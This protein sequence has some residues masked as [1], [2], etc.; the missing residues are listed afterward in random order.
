MG[1]KGIG[2]LAPFGIARKV[3]VVTVNNNRLNHFTLHLGGILQS[4]REFGQYEPPFESYD[5]AISEFEIDELSAV[6]KPHVA[7]LISNGQ[8]TIV[9]ASEITTSL[10]FDEIELG[11]VLGRRFSVILLRHDFSVKINGRELNNEEALPEFEFRIPSDAGAYVTESFKGQEVRFWAGFVGSADWPSDEA[12]VGIYAHGKIVQDRPFFFSVKGKELFQRYLY[13]VVEADWIDEQE[14]DLVST[15]RTSID[16]SDPIVDGFREWGQKKVSTW[17]D[18]YTEFRKEKQI[19]EL[20]DV[21]AKRRKEKVIPTFSDPE[22]KAIE[23]LVLNATQDLGKGAKAEQTRDELLLAVSQAW[24][25]LPT[26]TLIR[27]LW[28]SVGGSFEAKDFSKVI[29]ELRRH[30]VPESMGL[31]LTFA[32]RAYALSLLHDL[33]HRRGE[34]NLQKLVEEFPW[35][36]DP[37]GE[38]LT[39]DKW[40]KTTIEKAALEDESGERIGGI[41]SG[42]SDQE[43]ADFVFLSSAGHKDVHIVEIKKPD[44][45]LGMRESRQLIDYI[46]YTETFRPKSKVVGTLI[47]NPGNPRHDPK[48][49]PISVKSW[50]EILLECRSAYVD[51]L[52]SMIEYADLSG[53][54]SRVDLVKEFGGPE[55][56][57]MLERLAEEDEDLKALFERLPPS[58]LQ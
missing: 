52:A 58:H 3:E 7:T 46:Q 54:D 28:K 29:N 35:I 42:M 53:D 2:K 41:V 34:V 12:G 17:L 37:Y 56:W 23:E 55:V 44:L 48:F 51:L 20:E 49:T 8:G 10:P 24:M 6:L 21:A 27:N 25:N 11:A 19:K 1:R 22:N 38:L 31:A 30:S 26:R 5:V 32:Q 36:I 9:F 39:S 50:D 16:W 43:R 33:V 57:A 14:N 15:D 4:G 40:L 47:G 18:K 45:E 13:A